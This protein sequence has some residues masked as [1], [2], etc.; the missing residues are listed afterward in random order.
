MFRLI[1][2]KDNI[3]ED[4]K[5]AGFYKNIWSIKRLEPN[6]ADEVVLTMDNNRHPHCGMHYK[7]IQIV[8]SLNH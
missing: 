6:V 4:I 8:Y 3:V 1:K 2:D 7:S 5:K